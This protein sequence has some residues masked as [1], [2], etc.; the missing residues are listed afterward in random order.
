MDL[1][2]EDF[3]EIL[4]QQGFADKPPSALSTDADRKFLALYDALQKH[5][6]DPDDYEE[7]KA[8]VEA[9]EVMAKQPA[10]P[11]VLTPETY[12]GFEKVR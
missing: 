6:I 10:A 9:F 4:R 1:D 11:D 8:R 2:F 7:L 12:D 5:G 3:Y